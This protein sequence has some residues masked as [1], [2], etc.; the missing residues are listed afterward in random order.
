MRLTEAW[1]EAAEAWVATVRGGGDPYF[2]FNVSRFLE[3]LPPPG[4][5]TLDLGC[6]EGRV[7]ALLAGL[8]HRVTGVEASPVLAGYARERHEV[9][10]AD[11]ARLPFADES[12]DL[13][14]AFMSLHDMDDMPGAVA[15]AA[16]VL[17]RGGRFCFAAS[18]PFLTCADERDDGTLELS[19][20]YLQSRVRPRP[21]AGVAMP[22][23]HHPLEAYA[24][25][26]ES[27]GLAI[28][29]LRDVPGVRRAHLPIALHVRAASR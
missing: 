13:V 12:F 17:A 27:T 28:E 29:E 26:L 1:N 15:E 3:L 6:G 7:G 25:A 4:R 10:E 2:E 18:H 14:V 11:A 23:A 19:E 21:V 9:V 20:P 8:G 22:Q 5:A 24:D 16:R